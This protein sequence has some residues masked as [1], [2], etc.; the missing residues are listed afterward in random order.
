MALS[1]QQRS[2][3]IQSLKIFL[4][5]TIPDTQQ[6]MTY[7]VQEFVFKGRAAQITTIKSWIAF[8]KNA[9]QEELAG[10]TTHVAD[11]TAILNATI[12]LLDG[13]DTEIS[14]P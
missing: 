13:A 9:S 11:R 5:Q 8:A 7:L 10:L 3:I 2:V 1:A 6:Q 4:Q 12:A 14:A